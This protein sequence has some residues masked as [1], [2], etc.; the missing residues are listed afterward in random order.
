MKAITPIILV[1]LL[2]HRSQLEYR[3][4]GARLQVILWEEFLEGGITFVLE[5]P[6]RHLNHPM[7]MPVFPSFPKIR[8]VCRRQPGRFFRS[9]SELEFISSLPLTAVRL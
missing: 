6:R 4:T 2:H 3:Q 9:S 7:N 8:P 5:T 1:L